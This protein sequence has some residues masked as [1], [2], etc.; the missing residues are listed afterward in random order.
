MKTIPGIAEKAKYLDLFQK[1]SDCV[2]L[3]D[4][5]TFKIVDAN[6]ASEKFFGVSSAEMKGTSFCDKLWSAEQESSHQ[7][8]RLARRR[9][10]P[11]R[12]RGYWTSD[13]LGK[14]LMEM[15]VGTLRLSDQEEVIQIIGRDVT[16]EH[17]M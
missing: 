9:Y 12:S 10:H 5:Q 13:A 15:T 16:Q 2:L 7:I 14:C 3:L 11:Q 17:E 6:P 1:L 4:A 8:L